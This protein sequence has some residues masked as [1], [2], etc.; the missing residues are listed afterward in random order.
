MQTETNIYKS[1]PLGVG[2]DGIAYRAI[3]VDDSKMSLQILKQILL[4][5]DFVIV[6]EISNGGAAVKVLQ[7]PATHVDYLFIDVEMPVMDGIQVVK[8]V[9]TRIPKCKIIMVTSHSDREKVQDLIQLGID[10]Y[11]KKPFDRDT[12]IAKLTQI[13]QSIVK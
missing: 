3:I 13:Q 10:G 5:V 11:I 2:K 4:S 8:E 7:D 6:D 12:V 1:K 9:R